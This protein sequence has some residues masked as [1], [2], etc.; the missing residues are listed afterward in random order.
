MARKFLTSIDLNLSELQ[1]AVIQNLAADPTT[2]NTDGRIYYNTVAD[3]MRVYANGGWQA[4]IGPSGELFFGP[5]DRMT[6]AQESRKAQ[7]RDGGAA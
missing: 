3:E 7:K 4:K 1:N 5:W 2:G 6:H